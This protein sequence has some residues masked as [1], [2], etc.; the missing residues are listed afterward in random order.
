[1]PCAIAWCACA[2]SCPATQHKIRQ[3]LDNEPELKQPGM[4]DERMLGFMRAA[5]QSLRPTL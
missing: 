1:M 2:D 4:V 5:L 3:A